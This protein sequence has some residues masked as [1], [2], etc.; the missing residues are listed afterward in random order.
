MQLETPPA[1]RDASMRQA[2]TRSGDWPALEDWLKRRMTYQR[3]A[4]TITFA[5]VLLSPARAEDQI[6]DAKPCR[7][8]CQAWR[9]VS[10]DA[11]VAASAPVD[12]GYMPSEP[13]PEA[14]DGATLPSMSDLAASPGT[15]MALSPAEQRQAARQ[16]A[17]IKGLWPEG[18]GGAR[19][20]AAY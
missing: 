13:L 8:F 16:R 3:L 12:P 18:P 15:V 20:K 9:N 6:I 2:T 4:L 14:A 5:A 17:K 19:Q 7:F 10:H 11:T 1:D